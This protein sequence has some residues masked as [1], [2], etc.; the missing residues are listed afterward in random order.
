MLHLFLEETREKYDLETLWTVGAEFESRQE[1][2]DVD[3]FA[4]FVDQAWPGAAS[5]PEKVKLEKSQNPTSSL[6]GST[7]MESV[8]GW[9]GSTSKL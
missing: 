3:P 6:N 2:E 5:D 1:D 8:V 9:H 7:S 4:L